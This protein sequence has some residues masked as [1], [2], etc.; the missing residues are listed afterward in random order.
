MKDLAPIEVEDLVALFRRLSP[1]DLAPGGAK[2]PAALAGRLSVPLPRRPK[3]ILFDLYGTLFAS[4]AGGEPGLAS[5]VGAAPSEGSAGPREAREL[6]GAELRAAGYPRDPESFARAIDGGIE[7]THKRLGASLA[8]PE[9]DV[10]ELVGSLLPELGAVE[11]RRLSLLHEAWRNPCAP[12]RGAL[13]LIEGLRRGGYRLGIVSNAQFYTPLLFEALFG[14]SPAELGFE[15]EL[16]VYSFEL[17]IA[18]PDPEVFRRATAPLLAWGMVPGE[19]LAIGN[20]AAN[21]VLPAAALGLMTALFAGD[22]RSFRPAAALE[23]GRAPD[24]IVAGLEE[25]ESLFPPA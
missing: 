21:D 8:F 9:V 24:S 1:R 13:A 2:I 11:R 10:A 22:A 4:A 3:A 7:A 14:K 18:K 25:L 19:I 20:S 12:M 17:G 23:P 16:S 15:R 6:L 5:Q